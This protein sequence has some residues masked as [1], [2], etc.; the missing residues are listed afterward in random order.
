MKIEITNNQ[1]RESIT[2]KDIEKD[3]L[4]IFS[5][6]SISAVANAVVKYRNDYGKV[7]N[8]EL[9]VRFTISNSMDFIALVRT[10]NEKV[11]SYTL[12]KKGLYCHLV[13]M[14]TDAKTFGILD[15]YVEMDY[16]KIVL[17]DYSSSNINNRIVNEDAFSITM[18]SLDFKNKPNGVILLLT[19]LD[20]IFLKDGGK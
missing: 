19:I 20:K 2:S 12:D 11:C 1:S 13:G 10:L 7:Y 6:I 16:K 15:L 17:T 14:H 8:S 3:I 5:N 4:N 18:K 9:L